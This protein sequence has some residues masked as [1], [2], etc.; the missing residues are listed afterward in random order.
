[1][2]Q[3]YKT[4]NI[5]KKEFLNPH[6]FGDGLKLMEFGL[7]G[8]GTLSALTILLADGNNRGGGDLHAPDTDPVAQSVIGSWAGCRITI[9]GDYAD[10]G[11]FVTDED[12]KDLKDEDGNPVLDDA[13]NPITKDKINLYSVAG[14]KFKDVSAEALYCLLLDSY[15]QEECKTRLSNEGY[16][17]SD[18]IREL[19]ALV[20]ANTLAKTKA[21]KTHTPEGSRIKEIKLQGFKVKARQPRKIDM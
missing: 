3:Y 9:T 13:G 12:V 21:V 4:V 14:N 8:M 19:I 15:F 5:D 1:M 16:F 17:S 7:S 10:E 18:L 6:T 11:K 20:E 2:G